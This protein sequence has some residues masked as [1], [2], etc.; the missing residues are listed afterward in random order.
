ML[1]EE[2]DNDLKNAEESASLFQIDQMLIALDR[3]LISGA[4]EQFKKKSDE[5][6]N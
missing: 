6:T 1:L 3:T 5:R 4:K 2:Q